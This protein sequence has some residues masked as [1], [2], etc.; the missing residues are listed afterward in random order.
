LQVLPSFNASIVKGGYQIMNENTVSNAGTFD[1][2]LEA[3]EDGQHC[4]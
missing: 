3:A 1:P 2:K 4:R